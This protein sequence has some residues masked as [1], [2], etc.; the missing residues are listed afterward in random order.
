[1][2]SNFFVLSSR[3]ETILAKQYRVDKRAK[4][5]H[6]RSYRLPLRKIK[7]WDDMALSDHEEVEKEQQLLLDNKKENSM[8]DA[9]P[10]MMMPDGLTYFMSSGMDSSW[11]VVGRN[12]PQHCCGGE[13]IM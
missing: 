12:E 6:E 9:P 3:G 10:V 13:Y 8:G 2:I 5:D 11:S 4:W 7:F 1:M